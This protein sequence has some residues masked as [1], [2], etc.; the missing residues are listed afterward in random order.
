MS[1][2]HLKFEQK[3][4]PPTEEELVIRSRK[5]L[6]DKLKRRSIRFFSDKPVPKEVI[7]DILMVAS[8]APS[9]ANKQPWTFCAISN[10]DLKQKIRKA[11]EEEEYESYNG[12]MNK[13]WL[14]DLKKFDTDWH[15][16]FLETAP[17][18]IIVFKEIFELGEEGTKKQNYYVNESV[19]IACGFL[20]SAIHE[21]GLVALTHTPSP[22]NFLSELL[23][24]PKNERPFLLLPIG[25]PADDA[26]VPDIKKK[27]SEEVI[28][29]FD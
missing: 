19:G 6:T 7:E 14:E 27:T 24:R 8:S 9:G 28:N 2:Q 3:E 13:E 17:W 1:N 5:L 23:S 26:T 18:I 4:L 16:P 10:S 22:M 12:R 29:W 15:K 21:L 11:A 25:Y 20:I